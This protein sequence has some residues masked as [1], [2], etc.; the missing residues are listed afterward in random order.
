L[1]KPLFYIYEDCR[2]INEKVDLS[3]IAGNTILLTGASG[4]LGVYFTTTIT[5]F[6]KDNKNP[7][8]LIVTIHNDIDREFLELFNDQNIIIYQGDLTDNNF[9][10]SLPNIDHVIH[11]A[12]YGQPRR[13][14]ENPIKTLKLCTSVTLGLFEK[15]KPGGNFLFISTSEVYSGLEASKYK[16]S[17]IGRTNTTHYRSCYIEGKRSGEAICFA[18][19]DM[20]INAKSVRLALAYGPGTR[21]NDKRVINNFIEKA[22]NGK[23]TMLDQGHAKRTYC[24]IKDATEI[25]WNI[26]LF[27]KKPIYNVGGKSETTIVGLAQK[28]SELMGVPLEVPKEDEKF[29]KGAPQNVSLDLSLIEEEFNKKYFVNIADGLIKTIEWQKHL[30]SKK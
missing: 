12:G 25:M 29:Q 17:E 5:R 28:I 24:Y 18:Y 13:F 30:Y 8:K 23:I 16:E 1:N 6:N 14:M 21:K 20:G 2:N 19:K 11:T 3:T 7:I 10:Q 22:L 27:G 9:L 26:F 15:I 4:L